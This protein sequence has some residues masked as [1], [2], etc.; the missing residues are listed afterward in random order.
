MEG[1]VDLK[2]RSVLCEY[3]LKQNRSNLF[4]LS[5]YFLLSVCVRAHSFEIS[6]RELK[7]KPFQSEEIP[8]IS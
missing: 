7:T 3:Y 4:S 6:P 1:N 8:S 5:L 2:S